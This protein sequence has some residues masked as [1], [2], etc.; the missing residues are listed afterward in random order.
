[1]SRRRRY[2]GRGGPKP[3]Q[4][5]DGS[6]T[7]GGAQPAAA[8]TPSPVLKES[9]ITLPLGG[10]N[11]ITA[12]NAYLI[13][14]SKHVLVDP[15]PP[16]SAGELLE[17]LSL[18]GISL[19]DIGLIVI[20]HGHPDH[21]GSAAQLKEWTRA[22]LAVHEL[23]AEYLN[24]GSVPAPKPVTRLG[25]LF[26]SF[27]KIKC[28]PV[29]PDIILRDGDNL[30][31]YA[32]RGRV[33]LTPGHT[34]GSI[35]ILL[36]DGKCIIGDVLMRGLRARTPSSPWFAEDSSLVK[37]SLQKVVEAGARTLLPGRGGPFQVKDLPR[38]FPWLELRESSATPEGGAERER[39][40]RP[41]NPRPQGRETQPETRPEADKPRESD[42]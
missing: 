1:M 10:R 3:E 23:D 8:S 12:F 38:S 31:R 14:G 36:P 17:K 19:G 13:P 37:E 16:G 41:R 42:E 26:K 29:E 5:A 34:A 27:F 24:W 6:Q 20:T 39:R 21:F 33:L 28:R 35:S 22:P 4:A 25:S 2:G 7:S 18:H 11:P 40:F 32:G 9:V 15:G 30:G